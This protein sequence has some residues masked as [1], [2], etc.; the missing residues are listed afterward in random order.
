MQKLTKYFQQHIKRWYLD[1]RV[2][3]CEVLW[4]QQ[5]SDDSVQH[6]VRSCSN[7]LNP[8]HGMVGHLDSAKRVGHRWNQCAAHRWNDY[9]AHGPAGSKRRPTLWL[10]SCMSPTSNVTVLFVLTNG[11]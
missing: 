10:L 11:I 4:I 3:D 5:L 8:W 2:T 6:P 1:L 9:D 7:R